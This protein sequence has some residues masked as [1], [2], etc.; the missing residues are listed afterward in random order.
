M[1]YIVLKQLVEKRLFSIT[2][3]LKKKKMKIKFFGLRLETRCQASCNFFQLFL[4]NVEHV[5]KNSAKLHHQGP[6]S[7][8]I[9]LPHTDEPQ[10]SPFLS[11]VCGRSM[12]AN[13]NEN[14]PD[15]ETLRGGNMEKVVVRT[16][17]PGAANFINRITFSFLKID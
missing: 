13:A 12:S 17:S 9:L 3:Q 15:K 5:N 1:R 16:D 2:F 4:E 11:P 10:E 6:F 7:S 8:F 14:S